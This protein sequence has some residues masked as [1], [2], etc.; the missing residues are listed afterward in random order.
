M[1]VYSDEFDGNSGHDFRL[2]IG[3]IPTNWVTKNA[4]TKA[5]ALWNEMNDM[6]TKDLGGRSILPKW[7]DF[8]VFMNYAHKAQ[9]VANSETS[10]L[11]VNLDNE[12]YPAGEWE[13][14]KFAD[15]G[16]TSD[17][18]FVHMLGKHR[19][20]SAAEVEN[21]TA[22]DTVGIIHAYAQSRALPVAITG[23]PNVPANIQLSPWGRLF[24]DDDQTHEAIENL[25]AD[26]DMPPYDYDGYIGAD[27][28]AGLCT[29]TGRLQESN[30]GIVARIPTF[31]APL[32]LIQVE[33]DAK[34]DLGTLTK[35]HIEFDITPVEM[36]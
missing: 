6:A 20:T 8:K 12:A 26:N 17:E 1:K 14:S 24:G 33:V 27:H 9:V 28:N 22:M 23:D 21:S 5:K 10:P 16:E 31:H 4:Y 36:M 35:V 18:Y 13:Y 7:H 25:D 15:S 32:G 30:I 3:V 29:F 34:E 19:N 11:P 2:K